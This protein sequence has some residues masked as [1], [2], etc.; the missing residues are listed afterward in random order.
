MISPPIRTALPIDV[1]FLEMYVSI[2]FESVFYGV[3]GAGLRF[4]LLEQNKLLDAEF[5]YLII[6]S[7]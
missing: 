4:V 6:F 5:R 3:F 1:A 7:T 2:I